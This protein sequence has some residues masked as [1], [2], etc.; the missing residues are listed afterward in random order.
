M[1]I[2]CWSI[3]FARAALPRRGI[4]ARPEQILVTLGAQNA[5][6]LVAQLIVDAQKHV[7]IENPAYPDL[8]DILRQ[9][10]PN[11]TELPVDDGGLVLDEDVLKQS[12]LVFI[13]PA[14]N[15]R[16]RCDACFTRTSLLDLASQHDLLII[17][18]DYEFEM[19]FMEG[20]RHLRSNPRMTKVG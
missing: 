8:R 5:L 15:A 9:R 18:D 13:T 4:K 17:E 7:V 10:T 12:D 20:Q 11:I 3:T 16:P 19:N 1:T 2:Q 6:Y 14:I